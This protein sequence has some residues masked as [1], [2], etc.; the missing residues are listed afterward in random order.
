MRGRTV[1]YYGRTF[2]QDATATRLAESM[3]EATGYWCPVC[4]LP[5]APYEG[6]DGVHPCCYQSASANTC[7]SNTMD[8]ANVPV[9][10]S[11]A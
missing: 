3:I 8:V 10:V 11:A 5:R 4:G 9:G 1:T 2:V 6:D 7:T